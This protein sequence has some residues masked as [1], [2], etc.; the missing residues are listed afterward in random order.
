[1]GLLAHYTHVTALGAR[2]IRDG[3]LL[4]LEQSL[5]SVVVSV[6]WNS[7]PLEGFGHFFDKQVDSSFAHTSRG[8]KGKKGRRGKYRKKEVN[9]GDTGRTAKHSLAHGRWE[10]MA[11]A[12][13]FL[14]R[15]LKRV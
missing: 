11:L 13:G 7:L 12:E 6:L 15:K 1:M 3:C 14:G 4:H 10:R 2:S 8:G 5:L 9:E